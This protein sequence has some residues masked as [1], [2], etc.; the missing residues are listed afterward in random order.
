MLWPQQR[1]PKLSNWLGR[2]YYLSDTA[3]YYTE[4]SG[5]EEESRATGTQAAQT[6]AEPEEQHM[7]V[8]AAPVQKKKF[9]KKS[10]HMVR[11]EEETRPSKP[12][13]QTGPDNHLILIHGWA[14]RYTKR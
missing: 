14:L 11:D 10:I 6:A 2:G 8:T 9:K 12:E 4:L 7:P 1:G 3:W 13:D 5:R